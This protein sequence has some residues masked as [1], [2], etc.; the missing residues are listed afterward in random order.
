MIRPLRISTILLLISIVAAA[1]NMP[2]G[3]VP[4]GTQVAAL[5]Q[6]EPTQQ[7]T[8]THTLPTTQPLVTITQMPGTSTATVQPTST[9]T[10]V[11]T[12]TATAVGTPGAC[13]DQAKFVE[14][15]TI[16]D[17]SE[18]LPAQ[19]FIKTWRLQNTGTCTWS[20][21]YA[22]TFIT[23]DQMSG[24]SPLPLTGTIA[25]G[26]SLDVSVSLKAPGTVGTYKGNWEL[27]NPG[28]VNFGTGTNASQPFY[29]L[30]NV[31]EGVSQLN[32]G[33]ATW[34][35]NMD[36]A[37]NWYLL[38]TANTKF[39]Q[40]DSKLVMTAKSPTGGDEWG[41]SNK[42]SIKDYYLQATF[43]TGGSCSGLDHYGLLGRAPDPNKGYVLEFSCDGHY[44]LYT[45]DGKNYLALQEWHTAAAIHTGPNQTNIMGLWMK[46][47]T[48]RVYAN[49]F[50]LAEF[51]DNSYSQG[52]FG[53][54]IGPV[55]T[56]NFTVYVDQV[57]YWDL[58]GS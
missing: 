41:L 10:P 36:T 7:K 27:R 37:D 25:P 56:N 33:A 8:A 17:N 31:V 5:T 55:K 35:D 1:C 13:T 3:S 15:V 54:V 47:T 28:G 9:S 38:D 16:P 44:R 6:V 11:P 40:G 43:I 29:V 24:T 49:G 26:N 22:L 48:L 2:A 58:S 42:P 53:L 4:T 57:A 45:W 39:T 19:D 20:S 12:A 30:I 51:T 46:G 52:Q 32:L 14:D 23:G 21:A 18:M 50:K 34:T